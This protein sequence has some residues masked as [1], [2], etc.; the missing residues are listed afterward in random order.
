MERADDEPN[1]DKSPYPK[2]VHSETLS[3]WYIPSERAILTYMGGQEAENEE[4]CIHDASFDGGDGGY[5]ACG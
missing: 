1:T 2:V 5:S 3:R 4:E